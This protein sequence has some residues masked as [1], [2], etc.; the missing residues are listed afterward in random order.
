[1]ISVIHLHLYA[2]ISQLTAE[3]L[4]VAHS[5]LALSLISCAFYLKM[6]S[7]TPSELSAMTNLSGGD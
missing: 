4:L 1:M 2:A 6:A 5:Q 7:G 3:I